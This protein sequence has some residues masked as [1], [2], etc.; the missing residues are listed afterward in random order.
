LN[1]AQLTGL[2]QDLVRLPSVNPRSDPRAPA[3]ITG[4]ARI[5]DYVAEFLRKLGLDVELHEVEPGRPNVLGK[6]SSRGGRRAVAF[7][8]HIDTVS[9]AGMTVEPF[10]AAIRDGRL[11]GRGAADTKG[12]LAAG[13]AALANVMRDRNFRVGNLDVW[14]CALASEENGN[15]GARALMQR[16]FRADFAIAGEPTGNRIVHAHRGALWLKITTQGRTAHGATPQLGASAIAKMTDVLRHLFGDYTAALQRRPDPTL[17]P[18][19]VNVGVIQ[20][21]S[22]VNIVPAACEIQ[23]DRRLIPGETGP[24]VAA[25]LREA[26]ASIPAEVELLGPGCAPLHTDP[27]NPFVAA[28]AAATGRTDALTTAPWFCD[29]AVFAEHGIPAIAFGPGDSAQAHTPDEF[30]ELAQVEAAAEIGRRFLNS[31]ASQS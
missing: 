6:F 4:E 7:A 15:Q 13:L 23:L 31:L 14:F 22:G 29:A 2:L 20:G 26:L 21:G 12:S 1:A 27:R 28:L 3:N 25:A 30:I 16:G 5:A 18:A 8:P 10:A 9:V 11:Y 19:T 24:A 17:G